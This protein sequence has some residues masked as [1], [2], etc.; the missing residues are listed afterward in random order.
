MTFE[1]NQLLIYKDK[2]FDAV[3]LDRDR[4]S[5]SN[6]E[7]NDF[8]LKQ[9]SIVESYDNQGLYQFISEW[10]QI[11]KKG[12]GLPGFSSDTV[13]FYGEEISNIEDFLLDFI[14]RLTNQKDMNVSKLIGSSAMAQVIGNIS[15]TPFLEYP[16][17]FF[18][19]SEMSYYA[20]IEAS[21]RIRDIYNSNVNKNADEILALFKFSAT[22]G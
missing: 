7:I 3:V 18:K 5:S 20:L 16:E 6:D 4:R 1:E 9:L 13:G 8:I 19:Y 22:Q 15:T 11:K 2:W 10:I 17:K 14:A 21:L 12:T